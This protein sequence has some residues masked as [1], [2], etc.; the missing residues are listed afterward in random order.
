[1][2]PTARLSFKKVLAWWSGPVGLGGLRRVS[3]KPLPIYQGRGVENSLVGLTHT[4]LSRRVCC[5]CWYTCESLMMV[6]ALLLVASTEHP[7]SSL[8]Q[9]ASRSQHRKRVTALGGL[10]CEHLLWI[11]AFSL[12]NGGPLIEE[13]EATSFVGQVAPRP[14]TCSA[15]VFGHHVT[16]NCEWPAL[17]RATRILKVC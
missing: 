10:A 6:K 13:L 2:C 5:V 1:M 12:Y 17:R 9:S 3:S 14:C 16:V 4:V 11:R 8:M 15:S 7:V